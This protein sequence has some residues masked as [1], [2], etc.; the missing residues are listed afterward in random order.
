[1]E[2]RVFEPFWRAEGVKKCAYDCEKVVCDFWKRI[3]LVIGISEPK[4]KEVYMG[5]AD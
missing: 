5:D 3:L 1:M 4:S 2:T